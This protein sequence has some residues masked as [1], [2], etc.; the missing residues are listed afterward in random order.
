MNSTEETYFLFRKYTDTPRK[1]DKGVALSTGP[2]ATKEA[3][4]RL[5]L[6]R[7]LLRPVH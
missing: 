5:L 7:K 1:K 4:I 6:P 3:D 2:G